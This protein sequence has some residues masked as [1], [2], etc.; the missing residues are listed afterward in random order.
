MKP[1]ENFKNIAAV[2]PA[3]GYSSRMGDFKALLP[4]GNRTVLEHAIHLF[5]GI[6][7]ERIIVV[8]GYKSSEITGA[9]SGIGA[10]AVYNP[11]F[12]QGM[13][14][15]IQ[16][17]IS[18]V[19]DSDAFFLLPVDIPLVRPHTIKQLAAARIQHQDKDVLYPVFLG[20]RGHPPLLSSRLIPE[21]LAWNGAGGLRAFLSRRE[22]SAADIKTAD[23]CI[24]MDMDDRDDYQRLKQKLENRFIPSRNECL[25][26]HD[27]AGTPPNI[28][29]HCAA[30]SRLAGRLGERLNDSGAALNIEAIESAGLLHDIA[31]LEQHHEKAGA[32]I[33]TEYGFTGV[34]RH[35]ALH[36]DIEV[37]STP[38][39]LPEEIVYLADKMT[40]G[41]VYVGIERRFEN[42][43]TRF[44]GRP[45]VKQALD[46]R[47]AAAIE[48]I[49]KYETA[50][51]SHPETAMREISDH[52]NLFDEAR[53]D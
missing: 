42:A 43:Y 35:V 33:V 23:E 36:M 14:S 8:T 6:G 3:A 21:I 15:S 46:K 50:A 53:R 48:I 7:I 9:V 27:I 17:G 51:G 52:E 49:R 25:A 37:E 2:I 10:G 31:R 44:A 11:D 24:L 32:E 19:A 29:D 28:R 22:Q 1:A 13:L 12:D 30:V 4:L 40:Q 39:P 26:L 5:Q 45:D 20:E 47:Y 41:A 18:A 38:F 16:A 34:A